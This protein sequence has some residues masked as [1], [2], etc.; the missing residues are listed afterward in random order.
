MPALLAVIGPNW[1]TVSTNQGRRRLDMENDFVRLEIARALECGIRVIPV[2]VDGAEMPP[3]EELPA[4]LQPLATKNAI[5]VAH[6]SNERDFGVISDFLERHLELERGTVGTEQAVP[7]QVSVAGPAETVGK[8]VAQALLDAGTDP[9]TMLSVADMRYEAGE[10]SIEEAVRDAAH[11]GLVASEGEDSDWV[12]V[13]RNDL[14]LA[15]LNCGHAAEAETAFKDLL[16]DLVR[17]KE[18][19]HEYTRTARHNLADAILDAGRV[20]EAESALEELLWDWEQTQGKHHIRALKTRRSLARAA[21]ENGNW[22]IAKETLGQLP[23]D[24]GDPKPAQKAKTLLLRAWLADIDGDGGVAELLLDQA[25][26]EL[27]PF[28]PTHNVRRELDKYLETRV[29]GKPG[30]TTL[31]MLDNKD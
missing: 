2:L 26:T 17:V 24:G 23:K 16:V 27:A 30:G 29:P 7:S 4:V 6:H 1:L 11:A 28:A 25:E 13:K 10:H 21:L 19:D 5:T 14:A 3:S 9:K 20:S 12:L 31:W 18:N 15:K 8:A 22:F